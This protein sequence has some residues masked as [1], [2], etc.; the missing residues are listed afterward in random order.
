MKKIIALMI[1]VAFCFSLTA[2]ALAEGPGESQNINTSVMGNS[3]VPFA[4]TAAVAATTE[5][6][7][8]PTGSS[9]MIDGEKVAFTAFNIEGNNYF[10]LRDL[11]AALKKTPKCFSVSW[12][13]SKNEI[14]LK[15]GA[16]YELIGGEL[17]VSRDETVRRAIPTKA[18]L[19]YD[20]L[21][22]EFQAYVINGNNYYKLR[23]IARIINFGVTWN[24]KEN[25]ILIDTSSS[26]KSDGSGSSNYPKPFEK[27]YFTGLDNPVVL[28]ESMGVTFSAN[29]A[30]NFM[31]PYD[32]NI[33]RA[34]LVENKGK[35]TV[36]IDWNI[37]SQSQGLSED[38]M[39]SHPQ[40]DFLILEAGESII[41]RTAFQYSPT[42]LRLEDATF[43]LEVN[44]INRANMK[45]ETI[46]FD[47]KNQVAIEDINKPLPEN[48][49]ISG[50]I[51]DRTTCKPIANLPLE[52]TDGNFK[53]SATTNTN[54]SYQIAVYAYKNARGFYN[55]YAMTVNS[56]EE[57]SYMGKY[58][59]QNKFA[60]YDQDRRVIAPK[61]GDA[62][63]ID[64][65]LGKKAEQLRYSI[66]TVMDIGI[67]AYAFGATTDGSV[68]ATVPFHTGLPD[69]EREKYAY[70]HVFNYKGEL[71]F[72]KHLVDETPAIDVSK[73]GS[74]IATT[75]KERVGDRFNRAIVYDKKGQ[76]YYQT[77][78]ME[79]VSD[80]GNIKSRIWE[81][82]ISDDN[83]ILAYGDTGGMVWLVDMKTG[84]ML[85]S[86]STGTGQIR[87]IAFD[88]KDTVIYISSGDG[89]LRCFSIDGDLLWKVY[90]D[91]W[92]TDLEI[93]K[94]YIVSMSKASPCYIHTI[95]K[96]T[97]ESI[98]SIPVTSGGFKIAISPDESLIWYGNVVSSGK[99]SLSN[100][101]YDI[102][103]NAKYYL[104]VAG[105]EAV[106]SADSKIF[107]VKYGQ[108]LAVVNR[109]SQ[110]LWQQELAPDG[111]E[112]SPISSVLWMSSDGKYIVTCMNND[113]NSRISG[114]LCF[115]SR[116]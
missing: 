115:V 46:R 43:N 96:Y 81:V 48:V 88:R 9:V 35:Q 6:N 38:N 34:I 111:R 105:A 108:A 75:I 32:A 17:I 62:L 69:A 49:T 112:D 98:T 50:R 90:V 1:C 91:A 95:D 89:Y 74:L 54:G 45:S 13:G 67:Q 52:L 70:L 107:A 65:A 103:G 68:I 102:R 3:E 29:K 109:D 110:I 37:T 11:A 15:T 63:K 4:A 18:S 77:E 113:P 93:T 92:I 20:D 97:G 56:D 21:Y 99:A 104:G 66:D 116:K 73:D 51:V 114:Q 2:S 5:K 26:Y 59:G 58:A 71:L 24:A 16:P 10:K 27:G 83:R 84:K 76:I 64:I 7:A 47:L 31:T 72:K 79:N 22:A 87:K 41:I 23:D 30:V 39:M 12:D 19:Y 53:Y 61:P 36:F 106:F 55:E 86:V 94:N 80:I 82:Q 85:W 78:V 8:M 25:A 44:I 42:E 33:D 28:A 60:N 14:S 40:P 101:I 100:N 57:Y